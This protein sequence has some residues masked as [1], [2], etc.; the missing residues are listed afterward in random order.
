MKILIAF[1]IGAL[2][3]AGIAKAADDKPDKAG[4][5]NV[6]AAR[7]AKAKKVTTAEFKEQYAWVGKAQ[8]VHVVSYLGQ[9]DG[10][11]YISKKSRSGLTGKWSETILYTPLEDLDAAF[12]ASLPA[13]PVTDKADKNAGKAPA[14]GSGAHQR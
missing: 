12:R 6:Q 1:T 11:A 7:L 8:T 4:G 5:V 3:V 9:Q 14:S 2:A 10:K 13:N